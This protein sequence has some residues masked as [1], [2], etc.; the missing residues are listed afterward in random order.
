[1][2]VTKINEGVVPLDGGIDEVV[3]VVIVLS[4]DDAFFDIKLETVEEV[5]TMVL[6]AKVEDEH[7]A[8][9]FEGVV[10]GRGCLAKILEGATSGFDAI[11]VSEVL[12]QAGPELWPGGEPVRAIG[13]VGEEV[14]ADPIEG[15]IREERD[16]ILNFLLF[17]SVGDRL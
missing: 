7:V 6:I 17:G 14:R 4:T 8:F 2:G 3:E 1:M 11:D 5:E 12:E 10:G 15:V 13:D 9:V 16:C